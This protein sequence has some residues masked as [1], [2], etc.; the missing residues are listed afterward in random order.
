MQVETKSVPREKQIRWA[1]VIAFLF[2]LGL[3]LDHFFLHI[4]F[5]EKQ[6]EQKVNSESQVSAISTDS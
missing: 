4:L 1:L 6:R 2:V 5:Q 3:A